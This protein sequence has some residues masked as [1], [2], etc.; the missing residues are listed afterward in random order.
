MVEILSRNEYQLRYTRGN[1]AVLKGG[2]TQAVK[3]ILV[4]KKKRK[5]RICEDNIK[6]HHKVV[7]DELD[8]YGIRYEESTVSRK[9]RHYFILFQLINNTNVELYLH[10]PMSL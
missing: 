4:K 2:K 8:S 1:T 7:N 5:R 9:R 3:K 6:M 10:S